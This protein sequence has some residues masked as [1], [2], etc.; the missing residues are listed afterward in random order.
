MS[1]DTTQTDQDVLYEVQDRIATITLNRPERLNAWTRPMGEAMRD[2][3][4]RA[5]LDDQVRVILLTGAGRGFCAGADME[6]LQAVGSVSQQ[7]RA[8]EAGVGGQVEPMPNPSGIDIAALYN[9]RFGYLVACPKPVIAAINGACAGLGLV[10][11][12]YCD[13]RFASAQA[14]FTTAFSQRGLI[15]EHGMSWL[16]PRLIGNANALDL[17]FSAR[18]F[19]GEEAQRLGLVNRAFAP[20]ALMPETLAYARALAD[21][22]SPRSMAVM[23]AQVYGA[24]LQDFDS[25]LAIADDQMVQCFPSEDFREGVAHFL[26]KRPPRFT[27]R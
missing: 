24:A 26:E 16:L 1:M 23:K 3:V 21:T 20:E 7:D 6:L 9:Q 14:K 27:G 4:R 15:A 25:A 22:V 8:R 17:M 5:A 2:A 11:A 13:L 18:K 19:D 10:I 12:L